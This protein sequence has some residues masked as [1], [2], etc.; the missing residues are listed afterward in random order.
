[1]HVCVSRSSYICI[2]IYLYIH[3]SLSLSTFLSRFIYIYRERERE[4]ETEREK[5]RER[6]RQRERER[7]AA[8][9]CPSEAQQSPRLPW[10]AKTV[11]RTWGGPPRRLETKGFKM[12]V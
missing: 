7:Y 3:I 10:A 9:V 8:M 5:E 4:R 11:L 2:Y 6:E 1:M 12:R